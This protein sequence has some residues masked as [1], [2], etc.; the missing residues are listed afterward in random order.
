MSIHYVCDLCGD[1][2]GAVMPNGLNID[3][4]GEKCV[5]KICASR[6]GESHICPDCMSAL[7]DLFNRKEGDE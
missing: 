3:Y 6:D 5:A 7:R 1:T 2:V 4:V